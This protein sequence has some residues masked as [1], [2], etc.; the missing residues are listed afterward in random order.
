VDL[1]RSPPHGPDAHRCPALTP[2]FLECRT[3]A[4]ALRFDD[5]LST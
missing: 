3:A 5:A 1:T 2:A 4:S